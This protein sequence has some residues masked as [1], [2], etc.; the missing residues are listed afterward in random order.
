[1]GES[2][3][4]GLCLLVCAA[5]TSKDN[6]IRQTLGA[7]CRVALVCSLSVLNG[8]STRPAPVIEPTTNY[9]TAEMEAALSGLRNDI[10][11]RYGFRHGTPRINLGPCGRFARDFRER[12]NARFREPVTI[13]FIMANSDASNCYH[14]LTRLPD[15]RYFDGGNGVMTEAFLKRRYP[16]GHIEEMKDFDFELLDKRS[17]GLGRT[18]PECSNYSD[19][20]TRRAIEI[21]L[22]ESMSKGRRQ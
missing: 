5:R 21:H 10:N 13:V 9:S 18:Y 22:T 12:W 3:N 14:V 4:V 2:L 8:C 17:Y 15:G 7:L 16:D 19:E 1:M 11:A 20:F 6:V